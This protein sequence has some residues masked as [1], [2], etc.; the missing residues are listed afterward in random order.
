MVTLGGAASATTTANSSGAYS[1]SGLSN[2]SY[3]VTPS[4]TGYTFTPANQS[5][6]VSGANVSGIN[7]TATAQA[8]SATLSWTASTSTVVGYNVYRGTVSGG[9]YSRVNGSLVT[10]L[11][12]T[13]TTVLGG[14]TYYYV[15][16]A[17]DSSGTESVFSNEVPAVIP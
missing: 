7:F 9:P 3:T 10:A 12:Y 8:H 6:M 4:N 17:V 2:G 5:V 16:T 1:F 15:T 14:Q 13:D 11:T